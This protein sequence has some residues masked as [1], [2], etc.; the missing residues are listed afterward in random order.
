[1]AQPGGV[2]T[3][4]GHTE[5]GCD[6]A[7]LAGFEPAAVI[8]EILKEDGSMARRTDLELLAKEHGLKIGTISD[9]IRFRMQNEK[10]VE[11]VAECTLPTVFGEFR[12]VAFQ[13]AIDKNLH[14]ALVKGTIDPE[15]PTLVRV[16]VSNPLCDLTGCT[17]PEHGWPLRSVL[18][19]VSDEGAGVV[20]ILCNQFETADLI[21]Q[22]QSY[23]RLPKHGERPAIPKTQDLYTIGLGSQILS[24]V[25]VRKMR[26]LSAPKRIHSLS[27]FGLEVVEYV[28]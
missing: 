24:E 15:Q 12:M 22:A 3:R 5:A 13:D 8:V 14:L 9:L 4:A 2:L 26:V 23:G 7:R 27:G 1:M 16:H 20:V 28:S 10:T 6:I 11:R 17:L 18:Q 19:R 25:G 21:A